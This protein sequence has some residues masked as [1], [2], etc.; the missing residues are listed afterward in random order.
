VPHSQGRSWKDKMVVL[1][2]LE[3]KSGNVIMKHV[4][5]TKMKTL[6]P[7]IKDNVKEGSNLNTDE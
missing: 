7:I 3:R 6:V 1:E 5:D 2:M 4:P